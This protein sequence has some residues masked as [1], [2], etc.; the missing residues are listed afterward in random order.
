MKLDIADYT[1]YFF[2]STHKKSVDFFIYLC[3]LQKTLF[4]LLCT[5]MHHTIT[6]TSYLTQI[7]SL[8][9][10][11]TILLLV[12]LR[13]VGKSTIMKQFLQQD[14]VKNTRILYLP[15]ESF[16]YLGMRRKS[17][18]IQYLQDKN[19][20][21]LQ[22]LVIDE[23]QLVA[24][25]EEV[26]NGLH[27]SFPSLTIILTGS[28]SDLL[29]TEIATWLRWRVYQL[30]VY[31][32]DI[33]EYCIRRNSPKGYELMKEL[34][35]TT[36][37]PLAYTYNDPAY[38]IQELVN[39][40]FLKDIVERY[41]I[42]DV[43]L[44]RSIFAFL[45]SNAGNI[46]NLTKILNYLTSTW[47][48]LN[49]NTLWNYVHYLCNSLLIHECPLYDIRGKK[50]FDK[51]RKYYVADHGFRNYLFSQFDIGTGKQLENYVY[52]QLIKHHYHVYVGRLW[53]QEIDFIAERLGKKI[54]MQVTW[55]L[56]DVTV[57]QREF[58]SLLAIRDQ[59]PKYI[60]SMDKDRMGD[61]QNIQHILARNLT[62]YLV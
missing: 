52:L 27:A 7:N 49:L 29:S 6:R 35:I 59:W 57:R 51:L 8:L 12:G 36:W 23:V 58:S 56:E 31:P 3:I 15:L 62:D 20:A 30:Y 42:K 10:K 48:A 47:F 55:S 4:F 26:I 50:V 33:E 17:D 53:E 61:H 41:L 54:Y 22:Y 25:W 44:L 1:L 39:T 28:N 9:D 45:I 43:D 14:F 37:L 60:I 18:L 11:Q 5:T 46:T 40:V 34:L 19:L 32:F 21:T 2:W 38:I 13:R 24:G 16:D